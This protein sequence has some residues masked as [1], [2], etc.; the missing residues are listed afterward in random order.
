LCHGTSRNKTSQVSRCVLTCAVCKDI[1]VDIKLHNQIIGFVGCHDSQPAWFAPR[2]HHSLR[3]LATG[4]FSKI[5]NKKSTGSFLISLLSRFAGTERFLHILPI[6]FCSPKILFFKYFDLRIPLPLAGSVWSRPSQAFVLHPLGFKWPWL[7]HIRVSTS[8][9]SE[10]QGNPR[11]RFFEFEWLSGCLATMMTN[12]N[13][14]SGKSP[15][16]EM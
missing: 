9:D 5:Q 12:P 2:E 14:H 3:Y 13:S 8:I 11:H 15:I 16:F 4:F 7:I 6:C 10:T 1:R